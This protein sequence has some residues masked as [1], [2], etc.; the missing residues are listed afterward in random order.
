VDISCS[1]CEYCTRRYC[2]VK[3]LA[4]FQNGVPTVSTDKQ[5][6]VLVHS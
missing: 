6:S 2:V 5:I 3:I 1:E 4:C